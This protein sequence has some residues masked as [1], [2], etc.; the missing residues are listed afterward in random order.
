MCPAVAILVYYR[1]R[2]AIQDGFY[3]WL[4]NTM[5]DIAI[6]EAAQIAMDVKV[7]IKK[8]R[9]SMDTLRPR[10]DELWELKRIE[11]YKNLQKYVVKRMSR[12]QKKIVSIDLV[13]GRI[14]ILVGVHASKYHFAL[15][16]GFVLCRTGGSQL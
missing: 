7:A 14:N 9:K 10:M 8:C 1:R 2:L 12:A 6:Q 13:N 5:L 4:K 11:M 15:T 16:F 3:R